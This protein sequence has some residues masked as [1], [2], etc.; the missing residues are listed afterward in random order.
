MPL[1][2]RMFLIFGSETRGLPD[3]VLQCYP[4]AHYHVP[5]TRA[6]RSLPISPAVGIALYES[7][8]EAPSCHGW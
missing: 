2:A 8:R 3:A 4:D 5:I 6:I 1:Q 7:L